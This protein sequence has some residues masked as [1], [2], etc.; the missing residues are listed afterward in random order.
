MVDVNVNTTSL[1]DLGF[2][3]QK[4]ISAEL[5]VNLVSRVLFPVR[6]IDALNNN[7][8]IVYFIE[9]S[10]PGRFLSHQITILFLSCEL[11]YFWIKSREITGNKSDMLYRFESEFLF[12]SD[13]SIPELNISEFV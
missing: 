4:V 5:T 9:F 12:F 1:L 10:S 13:T 11:V 7:K 8:V 2:I 6:L 3:L